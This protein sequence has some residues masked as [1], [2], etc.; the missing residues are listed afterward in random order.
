MLRGDQCRGARVRG[1]AA[2]KR[3]DTHGNRRG[4]AER[5]DD[6]VER[7]TKLIGNDLREHGGMALPLRRSTGADVDLA[8]LEHA[9]GDAFERTEARA[10][11]IGADADADVA[12][13]LARLF[14][15]P[16]KI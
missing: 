5:H 14:L 8:V 12:A 9:H 1:D 15:A 4:I 6:V 10:L 3:A 2:R 13:L 16:R 11:D 7:D